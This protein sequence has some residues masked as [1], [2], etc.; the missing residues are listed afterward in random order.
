MKLSR[1]RFVQHVSSVDVRRRSM[2]EPC[3]RNQR[4]QLQQH[5]LLLFFV[6]FVSRVD[7][8]AAG[9]GTLTWVLAAVLIHLECHWM[10]PSIPTRGHGLVLLILVTISFVFETLALLSW[11]SPLWWWTLRKYVISS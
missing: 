7:I 10:L 9:C 1:A 8:L 6:C 11:F 5:R 4:A 2:C 3:C